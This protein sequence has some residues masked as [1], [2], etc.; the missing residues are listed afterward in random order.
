LGPPEPGA[1]QHPLDRLADHL[2]RPAFELVAQR[3]APEPTGIARVAVVQLLVGRV[4]P[5]LDLFGGG[6]DDEVTPVGVRGVLR[7]ALAARRVGDASREPAQGLALGV[8]DV[9]AASHFARLCVPGLLHRSGALWRAPGRN[10]SN[11]R[12]ISAQKP[13]RRARAYHLLNDTP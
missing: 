3:T 9:P 4:A 6:H 7:L 12:G 13:R 10:G 2:G 11:K 1:R 5:V 8:D